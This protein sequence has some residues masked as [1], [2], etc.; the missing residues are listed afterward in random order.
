MKTLWEFLA[1]FWRNI[2][3]WTIVNPWE[4][5]IRVRFGK[6]QRLLKPG[7]HFKLPMFDSVYVQSIR[8]R[9]ASLDTQTVQTADGRMVIAGG[10]IAYE[11]GDISALYSTLHHPEDSLIRDAMI[12]L[13]REIRARDSRNCIAHAIEQAALG[14][15]QFAQ[16]GVNL[17]ELYLTDFAFARTYRLIN[18]PRYGTQGDAL[19]TS[20][21]QP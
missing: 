9:V 18:A 14:R 19:N 4:Q 10:C 21:V 3:P 15:L 12:A 17:L 8:R 5:A 6:T 2:R 1:T 7:I 13:A 11:I 16:Y 20:A